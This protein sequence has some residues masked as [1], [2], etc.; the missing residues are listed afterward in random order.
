MAL[1]VPIGDQFQVQAALQD[2]DQLYDRSSCDPLLISLL[3]EGP[4]ILQEVSNAKT[5]LAGD[6]V[7]AR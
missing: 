3:T 6:N 4:Q 5:R 7:D 1:T 2:L